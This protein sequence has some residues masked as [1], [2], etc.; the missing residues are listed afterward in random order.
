MIYGNRVFPPIFPKVGWYSC[1]L[2]D[3]D[4]CVSCIKQ[5]P[6]MFSPEGAEQLK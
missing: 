4:L 2:C 1:G 3:Y 5:L 6:N